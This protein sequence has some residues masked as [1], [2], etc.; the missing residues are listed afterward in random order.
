MEGGFG[1]DLEA[2]YLEKINF[3]RNPR[4]PHSL[5]FTHIIQMDNS[6]NIFHPLE[7]PIDFKHK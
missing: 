6:S 2:N 5:H 3:K 7:F 4:P 1:G